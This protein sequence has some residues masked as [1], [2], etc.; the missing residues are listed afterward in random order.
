M[1]PKQENTFLR[2]RVSS[3]KVFPQKHHVPEEPVGSYFVKKDVFE[4]V[5]SNKYLLRKITAMSGTAPLRLKIDKKHQQTV[6]IHHS[7][8]FVE[9]S[10]K[11]QPSNKSITERHTIGTS[12][13]P[14]TRTHTDHSYFE[15][16]KEASRANM[17]A[18][19]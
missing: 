14:L 12:Y 10:K 9:H 17:N 7:Q 13:K 19:R 2:Y 18:G 8:Y 6:Q 16:K 5:R 11:D 3:D 4:R 15:L 1:T